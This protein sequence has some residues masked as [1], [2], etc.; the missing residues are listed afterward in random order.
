MKKLIAGVLIALNVV[1]IASAEKLNLTPHEKE[2]FL[3]VLRTLEQVQPLL[4]KGAIP[5]QSQVI[6]YDMH[7][8]NFETAFKEFEQLNPETIKKLH[9]FTFEI[10]GQEKTTFKEFL[11]KTD[12]IIKKNEEIKRK[13]AA[14]KELEYLLNAIDRVQ[15]LSETYGGW[16]SWNYNKLRFEQAWREFQDK[17]DPD[18][19]EK[20]H[21][22]PL[23]WKGQQ[24]TLQEL[25]ART[26]GTIQQTENLL[27]EKQRKAEQKEREQRLAQQHKEEEKLRKAEARNKQLAEQRRKAEERRRKEYLRREAVAKNMGYS[28]GLYSGITD[29]A[30]DLAEDWISSKEAQE[31][32]ILPT[33]YNDDYKV[34]NLT[35]DYVF[36]ARLTRNYELQQ[37]A[38]LRQKNKIYLSETPLPD[39]GYRYVGVDDFVNALGAHNQLLIFAAVPNFE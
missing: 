38:V 9:A 14:E 36:Y 37:I 8:S 27:A 33:G 26:K 1:T 20:L 30:K 24:S 21:S 12:T 2:T 16:K 35:S 19:M 25:I 17:V 11:K 28:L 4:E 13:A 5:I 18:V 39:C 31:Y 29:F 7:K 6:S 34:Q 23:T 22:A 3:W 15:P 32:I 10:E